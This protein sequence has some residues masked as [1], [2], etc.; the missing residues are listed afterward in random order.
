MKITIRK[1]L[2]FSEIGRKDNQEDALYPNPATVGT[3]QKVFIM[4]D[5][6]GGHEHGEVASQTAS[7]VL[8]ST[9]DRSTNPR[10]D[11]QTAL[12]AAYD[13]LDAKDTNDG[14]KKMGTTMTCLI[15]DENGAMIA[16]IGDS[17]VYHISPATGLKY[18]TT[19]H[20]LVQDL[21]RGGVIS[22]E[23]AKTYPHKNI[24]TRAMQPH[25][26]KRSKAEIYSETNIQSGDYF[27]LCCD[28]VLEQLTNERLCEILSMSIPDKDKLALI[29]SECDDKTRDNYTC[30]LIA[31]DNV[32]GIAEVTPDSDDV[33][34][35]VSDEEDS[36]TTTDDDEAE[37]RVIVPE[38][39][40]TPQTPV[41]PTSPTVPTT[42]SIP[43]NNKRDITRIASFAA[44]AMAF[45]A[46]I[47]Y[48]VSSYF[49]SESSIHGDIESSEMQSVDKLNSQK[50]E[51]ASLDSAS[52]VV[53]LDVKQSSDT[54]NINQTATEI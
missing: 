43:H 21:L 39:P 46:A 15:L 7:T 2:A 26:E 1:P 3:D 35:A 47:G 48:L 11:F 5:G 54:I 45:I 19:D 12:S 50:P 44:I 38:T 20:S 4:C 37:N 6:M 24:I 17:R 53:P 23:E 36:S 18:Q 13:A 41:T 42:S 51:V 10:A 29:K 49:G 40:A 25:Q 16:H 8:G 22:E 27:F 33:I 14:G 32:E 30:W 31:I 34:M 9:L 28:G 52:N